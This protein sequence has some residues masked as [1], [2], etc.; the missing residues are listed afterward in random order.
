M[1]NCAHSKSNADAD[2]ADSRILQKAKEIRLY[3]EIRYARD[4]S[5]SIPKSSDI[6]KLKRKY[7]NL[8]VD[9]YAM[10]LKIYLTNVTSNASVTF[11]DFSQVL[12]DL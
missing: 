9:E 8:T 10:N 11:D 2:L 6:F 1:D 12:D 7:K 5:L 4:C 3:T